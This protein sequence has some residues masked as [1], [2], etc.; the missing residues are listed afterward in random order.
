MKWNLFVPA[1]ALL[2]G[3]QGL[4]PPF[5]PPENI[6]LLETAPLFSPCRPYV[7]KLRDQALEV[8][9]PRARAG[10]DTAQMIWVKKPHEIEMYARNRWADAPSHMLLP[11]LSQSLE[12][13][14]VLVVQAP[15]SIPIKLRLD[16]ELIRLQQDFSVKP[17]QVRFTLA[18]KLIDPGARRVI[19]S[20]EFDET[21]NAPSED[22]YGGVSA[23]NR[24]LLRLL[25]RLVAFC[26][27][28]AQ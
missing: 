1:T 2:C 19:A 14:G 27:E 18:A 9:M 22:A 4:L 12:C 11:L 21:E 3:C 17:S 23:A 26:A 25:E 13:A 5:P 6:Y 16:T 8:S 15:S 28:H 24:A 7:A 20:A 10:F